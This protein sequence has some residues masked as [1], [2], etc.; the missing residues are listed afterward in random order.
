M[1]KKI[2]LVVKNDEM[3]IRKA[4]EFETWL[5]K[6]GCEIVRND[7]QPVKEAPPSPN[8]ITP[9]PHKASKALYCVFALGGDGT[10]LSAA[11]WIGDLEIPMLG[12]KFGEVGFLAEAAEDTFFAVAQSILA[13]R[14]TTIPRTRLRV[15]VIRDGK[16]IRQV[17]VLNDI[18]INKG[19]LA[20]LAHIDTYID[21]SYL[22]TYRSDGLIVATPTGSTAYSLA[23][24]GPIIHPSVSGIILT[25]ICPFT[26]TN[27]PLIIPDNACIKIRISPKS[28]DIMLT[29]DGQEGLA[30]SS[31][32]RIV[33]EKGPHPIHMISIKDLH[34]YDVLKTKLKWSGSRI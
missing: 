33:V 19:A 31:Q 26:L 7:I 20:R 8:S 15:S 14:F 1:G 29:F 4:D 23:A 34:Y 12:V 3:A 10:F 32:D 9:F 24:G 28:S 27:R 18:V 11:R 13:E 22:T 6:E 2:G 25:P 16:T 17:T 5:V 30:I 21:D